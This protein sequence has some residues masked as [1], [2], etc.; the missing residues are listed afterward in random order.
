MKEWDGQQDEYK[1]G[2]ELDA[3]D[4]AKLVNKVN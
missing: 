3:G 2:Q 1:F 4:K